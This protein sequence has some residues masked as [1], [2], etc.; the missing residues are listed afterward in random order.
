MCMALYCFT[1]V[2]VIDLATQTLKNIDIE[3]MASLLDG[4][5]WEPTTKRLI[6]VMPG[7]Q[8]QHPPT[9]KL[10]LVSLDP[11]TGKF[12]STRDLVMDEAGGPPGT[13]WILDGN[14]GAVHSYISGAGL[15]FV[16]LSSRTEGWKPG[17]KSAKTV[18]TIDWEAGVLLMNPQIQFNASNPYRM[19]STLIWVPDSDE[20]SSGERRGALSTERSLPHT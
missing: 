7:P 15:Y 1:G 19:I 2:A 3:N 9:A 14:E 10:N 8:T 4:M 13:V 16:L 12:D 6:G 17:D 18:A 11:A 20:V 5:A